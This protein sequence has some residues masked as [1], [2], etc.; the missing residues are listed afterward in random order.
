MLQRGTFTLHGS[1]RFAL[2]ESQAPGLMYVPI[3]KDDKPQLLSDLER[4]GIGEMSLFPETEHV[5]NH[6]KRAADL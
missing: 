6:L 2:D 5:C 1:R 3:L 4:I